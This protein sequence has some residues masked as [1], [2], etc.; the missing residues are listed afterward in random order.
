MILIA[1]IIAL[2]ALEN[3]ILISE[4][5]VTVIIKKQRGEIVVNLK[6]AGEISNFSALITYV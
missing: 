4:I 2:F 3:F 6:V 1:Y 5:Q